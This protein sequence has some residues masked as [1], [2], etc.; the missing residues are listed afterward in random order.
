[1][2]DIGIFCKLLAAHVLFKRSKEVEDAGQHTASLLV[3]GY[4]DMSGRL[5]TTFPSVL[6]SHSVTAIHMIMRICDVFAFLPCLR[7][8]KCGH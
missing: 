8:M 5:Q 1:M 4:S 3:N 7:L 6:I 2:L